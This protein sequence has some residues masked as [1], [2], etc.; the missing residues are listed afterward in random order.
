MNES[1]ENG[2][3]IIPYNFKFPINKSEEDDK[4]DCELPEELARLLKQEDKEIQP[5]QE[6]VDLINMGTKENKKEV[7]VGTSLEDKIK[8][9]LIN[10][11]HEYT[12]V[13][14]RSYQD[15]PGLD[16]NIVVHKLP[17]KPE[18]PLVKKNLRRILRP[19]MSLKIREEVRNSLTQGS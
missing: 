12:I 1:I 8:K 3:A 11:L 14:A 5:H 6:R 18:C 15:M 9:R 13:F 2:I 19:Y 17:L 16:M 4:D 10:L 7:K